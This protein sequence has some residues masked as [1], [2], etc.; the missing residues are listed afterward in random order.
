MGG[1]YVF[2]RAEVSSLYW[3]QLWRF[4]LVTLL[5]P[6]T[7]IFQKAMLPQVVTVLAVHLLN[8]KCTF[9]QAEKVLWTT[10][11]V[12]CSTTV[13]W[14]CKMFLNQVCNFFCQLA[15]HGNYSTS[16]FGHGVFLEWRH[17]YSLNKLL[18][19]PWNKLSPDFGLKDEILLCTD[20]MYFTAIL[21]YRCLSGKWQ[22]DNLNFVSLSFCHTPSWCVHERRLREP[23]M[24]TTL[25]CVNL[26]LLH[27]I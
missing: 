10:Y 4:Q 7:L 14:S 27:K 25:Y 20:T 9:S 1:E 23:P 19:R 12:L 21:S 17:G 11:F 18:N 3:K 16:H 5:Q 13:D 6:D 24:I 15:S 2:T 8:I 26:L 22:L